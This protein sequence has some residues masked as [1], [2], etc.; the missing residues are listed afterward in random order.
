MRS[1]SVL[2]AA[3]TI[4][5]VYAVG[6]RLFGRPAGLIAALLVALN[7]FLLRYAQEVRSY[8]LV[9]LL[10]T[11]SSWFLIAQLDGKRTRSAQVGYVVVS[12]AAIHAHFFAAY[13]LVAHAAYIALFARHKARSRAWLWQ[14]A[15]IGALCLPIAVASVRASS[16]QID[17][18]PESDLVRSALCGDT[19][20]WR[21][22]LV[23]SGLRGH[24]CSRALARAFSPPSS[25]L[26]SPFRLCRFLVPVALSFSVSELKPMFLP[27]YLIVCLPALGIFAGGVVVT[28]RPRLVGAAL[29]HRADPS[30]SRAVPRLVQQ[31]ADSR[32]ERADAICPRRHRPGRRAPDPRR[33][34]IRL[35]REPKRQSA[36]GEDCVDR[37]R[38]GVA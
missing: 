12:A 17:W 6:A 28:V 19:A 9:T 37:S 5:A 21:E 8:A 36:T 38:V 3:M 15:A 35:L 32:L 11:L 25:A 30:V 1:L 20:R 10:V 33:S 27:K 7:A 24:R 23:A 29:R 18:I 14:Y 13:V 31:A 16:A 4:P 26:G 34:A 22:Q 2:F